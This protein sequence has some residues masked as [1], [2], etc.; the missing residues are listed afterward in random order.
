MIWWGY[1]VSLLA[2]FMVGLRSV[3]NEEESAGAVV[4]GGGE[5]ISSPG[6]TELASEELLEFV[7]HMKNGDKSVL[8]QFDVQALLLECIRQ[9]LCSTAVASAI[10]FESAMLLYM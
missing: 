5:D 9:L 3:A 8:S 10:Y 7:V 6:K 2:N 4:R 1:L